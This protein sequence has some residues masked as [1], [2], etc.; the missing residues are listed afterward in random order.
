MNNLVMDSGPP[1]AAAMLPHELQVAYEELR[2]MPIFYGLP[3]Q[4]LVDALTSGG[5][6]CRI[7]DRDVFVADPFTLSAGTDPYQGGEQVSPIFYVA[8]GQI[9]AAVFN[10]DELSERR[11][12]QQRYE[13]MSDEERK[14]LSLLKPPPLAR[15][16][17]KN[18]AAFMEGDLFNS[19]ALAAGGGEPVAFYTVAPT[20]T[21][22]CHPG[23]IANL[24]VQFPFFEERFRRAVQHSRARLRHITGVKQELLDFFV[25][26][27]ISVS[28][29][30]VRVRQLDRCIDCKQCEMACEERY[31]SRRLTLGGYQ[32]GML[33]FVYTCRTCTDQRCIDPCEYDSIKF[34]QERG[35]VVI[36][37][38]SC[39]GCTL[40]AQSCP[41][42][43][44][45]M[46]DVEDPTNPTYRE[47]FKLRLDAN[48]ALRFGAGAPR[49]ARPRRI[50]N[51]CDHCINYGDQACVS[52]CP[53]GALIELSAYELF[54]ERPNSDRELARSGYEKALK[55]DS[56]ELLPTDPFTQGIGVS[57]AGDA[58]V[59]RGRLI[60]VIIWG[61]G[62]AV[63]LLVLAEVLLRV[64]WPESSLQYFLLMLV[65]GKLPAQ[66]IAEVNYRPGNEL[67][68]W[69]GYIGTS[70]MGIS[71]IYPIW[72][73]VRF[74]RYIASNTMWFDFHLMAGT[75][76]PM[77]IILHS[78]F[79]L[80]NWVSAAFWSM[81]IVVLSG[82]IG[83]Y[84]YTQVP[85]LLNGRQLEELDHQR[86][87]ARI[88]QTFPMA[89]AE[90]DAILNAQRQRA[91][92]I[93][94]KAG[95]IRTLV[96]IV[97]EDLRRP[98]RWLGRRR[99]F[100]RTGAPRNVVREMTRR[101][102]RMMIID[103]RR[104]I[105]PSAQLLLHSWKKVHVP[106]TMIMVVI[107][108][109]HIWVAFKYSM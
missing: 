7:Y 17:R 21:A 108:L 90:S 80:D 79:V 67:T 107:S 77:F 4:V 39:T 57:D 23:T 35:E 60:P 42:G 55:R 49:V 88:Q 25:R 10:P 58:K 83:R 26:Q 86:A 59:R 81:I 33:D 65:P 92:Y 46:V 22:V 30:K 64:Y 85:D 70:L 28:G 74:F 14:E 38:A 12:E 52:A 96:W 1:P 68:L 16:A 41:Y 54:H 13:Q 50:A 100:K 93:A 87:F 62:L 8:Q 36:N 43:A 48:G 11:A 95:V 29:E 91:E 24:A 56:K 53:T 5:I 97:M 6:E 34:D 76:G 82:A 105:V 66:A 15:T 31:G 89:A 19:A 98:G 3:D 103:R 61:V 94:R 47:D 102:G 40:C 37:E 27:G 101:T 73:R 71:A 72:R 84:L 2:Q 99:I 45:E 44:I 109:V 104:V 20:V 69:C 106:F 75:V 18:L 78:A 51:K 32:L 63:W 9:A